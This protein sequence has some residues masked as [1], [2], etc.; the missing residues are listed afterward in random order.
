[1]TGGTCGSDFT[2]CGGLHVREGI[3]WVPQITLVS[4]GMMTAWNGTLPKNWFSFNG[5]EMFDEFLDLLRHS[6]LPL[7]GTET[8]IVWY[9]LSNVRM[10][11][12]NI[13]DGVTRL[14]QAVRERQP[15]SMIFVV[16]HVPLVG[17]S[18]LPVVKFNNNL[19]FTV[20]KLRRQGNNI[21]TIALH[22]WCLKQRKSWR[23]VAEVTIE[24]RRMLVFLILSEVVDVLGLA[25]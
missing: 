7:T 14:Q 15:L 1:M 25:V 19:M 13:I 17:D 10:Q 12:K 2:H 4:N 22:H 18:K 8:T 24:D 5:F 11:K 23:E 6:E 21:R 9:V 16:T 20:H 3:W